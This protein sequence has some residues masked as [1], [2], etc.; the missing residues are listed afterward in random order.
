MQVF[1][2]T[3]KLST[4][5]LV[6][7]A[8]TVAVFHI[9]FFRHAMQHTEG[10]WNAVLLIASAALLMLVADFLVYYLM[11]CLGRIAGKCVLAFTMVGNAVMLYFVNSFEVLITRSMMANVFN[12]QYSEASSFFSWVLVGYVVL[13]GI[14]PC[15]YIF[16]RRTDQG[17]WRRFLGSI[18][19]AVATIVALLFANMGNM[20]WIDRNST[21]LG[22]LI[23]PWSYV[24][25]TVRYYNKQKKKNVKEIML[26]DGRVVTESRDVCV[27]IIGESARRDHF[28]YY[29]YA[30]DTNP[31]TAGDSLTALPAVAAATNTISAVRAMLQPEQTDKLYEI[32]PNYL[33]RLGVEVAWRTSNWGE[34]PTHFTNY[35]KKKQLQERYPDAEQ[36]AYDG[37][38]LCGLEDEIRACENAKQFVVLHT[39]TNHGPT[40]C[41]NYPP[42]FEVFKPVC[43]TVEMA[44]ANRRELVNAYDNSIIYTDYLVHSVI[45]MLRDMPDRRSCVIFMSD[46]GESLGENNLYMHGVPLFMAPKEQ[47]EI[48]FLVWTSDTTMNVKPTQTVEQYSI[49]HSVLDFLGIDSPVLKPAMSVFSRTRNGISLQSKERRQYSSPHNLLICRN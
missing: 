13:L 16:I 49:Y 17:S 23:A 9:P 15:I 28:R 46:H 24:V 8:Y 25:N 41:N 31:Y 47:T 19:I 10:G 33:Y 11:L 27:L 40:Y 20:L 35:V 12:T 44:H 42:Q 34:P 45:S 18:G 22:S 14:P 1:Q 2:K 21:E 38:L 26:P 39:Y 30:R 37:I 36:K 5:C 6:L 3:I 4:K 43:K 29:G 48:P 32:L 7:A